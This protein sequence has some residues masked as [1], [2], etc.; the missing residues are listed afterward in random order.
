[1]PYNDIE[2]PVCHDCGFPSAD[3]SCLCSE[4]RAKVVAD[5][6]EE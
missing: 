4:C 1:M 6:I 3:L 5:A 2:I